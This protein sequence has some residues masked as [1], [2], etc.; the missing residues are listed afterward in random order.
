MFQEASV[1]HAGTG[2]QKNSFPE[3]HVGKYIVSR[4]LNGDLHHP[5]T[6][7]EAPT[8]FILFNQSTDMSGGAPLELWIALCAP[9]MSQLQRGR[10]RE[11]PLRL[12]FKGK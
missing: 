3:L 10:L 7:S 4:S 2:S 11:H 6:N 1:I 12:R 5:C 9:I 8:W